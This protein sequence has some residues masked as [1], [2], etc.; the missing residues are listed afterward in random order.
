MSKNVLK[1]MVMMGI[2]VLAGLTLLSKPASAQSCAQVTAMN[3]GSPWT[4]AGGR[5]GVGTA[6][7][8]CANRKKRYTVTQSFT[9]ACG[10]T[11]TYNSSLITFG[12]GGSLMVSAV[13]NVP[14]DTCVG[15]GTLSAS[16][17][18]RGAMLSGGSTPLSI[19]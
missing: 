12:P 13:L 14:A 4:F 16:V 10:Q 2:T 19:Q 5:V 15:V 18:D 1:V 7:T 3:A 6:I 8:N 9:S 11:T 17:Y